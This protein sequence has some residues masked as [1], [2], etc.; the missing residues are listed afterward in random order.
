MAKKNAP[1]KSSKPKT[2]SNAARKAAPNTKREAIQS[3]KKNPAPTAATKPASA[4]AQS[5]TP[6]RQQARRLALPAEA[7]LSFL[8]DTKGVVSWSL[9]DLW[10][11]L[12]ISREEAERVVSLLQ[13]QGYVQPESHKTGEWLTTPSGETVSGAKAP[14]FDRETLEAALTSLKQRIEDSNRDRAAKFQITRAVAFGDFLAKDRARVQPADVGI[15]LTRQD[16]KHAP[17]EIVTPHS[18][19][20]AREEQGFLRQ[21][22]GRSALINL[23]NYSE[24][25]GTRT[26]QK[27]A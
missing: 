7:A 22:R 17:D 23:K 5:P 11:T 14:R 21:L 24:W 19:A 26:H 16:R 20:E 15:E 6:D 10:H 9:R 18:A 3:E 8:R 27:L 25:M 13:I 12:N 4:H 1:S 2:V